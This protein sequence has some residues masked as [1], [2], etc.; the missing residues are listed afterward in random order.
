MVGIVGQLVLQS[1]GAYYRVK[2]F[3]VMLYLL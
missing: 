1:V 3:Q 2:G